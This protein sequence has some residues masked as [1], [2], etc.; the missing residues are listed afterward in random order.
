MQVKQL[1]GQGYN[2]S[3]RLSI[4]DGWNSKQNVTLLMVAAYGGAA[5]TFEY[6]LN[7]SRFGIEERDSNNW[8]AYHYAAASV[9]D[10]NRAYLISPSKAVIGQEFDDQQ[11]DELVWTFTSSYFKSS[12]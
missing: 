10:N 7:M 5:E 4:S 6:I 3:T 2:I 11:N 9:I 1:I 12:F 8:M